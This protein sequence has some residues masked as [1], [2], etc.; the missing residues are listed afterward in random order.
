MRRVARDGKSIYHLTDTVVE[1]EYRNVFQ[2][3]SIEPKIVPD[4]TTPLDYD[5][6]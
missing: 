3:R 5:E 6:G 4:T 2:D 1:K